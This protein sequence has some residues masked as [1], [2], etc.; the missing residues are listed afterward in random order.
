MRGDMIAYFRRYQRAIYIVVTVVIVVSF[1]FFGT[2]SSLTKG[3]FAG[4]TV[5][6]TLVDGTNVYRSDCT[7]YIQFLSTNPENSG[8][9]GGNPLNDGF[10][11]KAILN[12]P[13]GDQL[14]LALGQEVETDMTAKLEKEKKYQPYQHPQA[15]FVSAVNVWT[16]FAP[17]VKDHFFQFQKLP[18]NASLQEIYT[19]KKNLY[20]AERQFPAVYLKQILM[21]QQKQYSWLEADVTLESRNMNLMGYHSFEEWFGKKFLVASVLAIMNTAK[22]AEKEGLV[23]PY[24][25]AKLCLYGNAKNYV[26][27]YSHDQSISDFDKQKKIEEVINRTLVSYGMEEHDAIEIMRSL[28]LFQRAVTEIPSHIVTAKAPFQNFLQE[29]TAEA[30]L[31]V[32]RL[33]EWLRGKSLNDIVQV[34]FWIDSVSSA[35]ARGSNGLDLPKSFLPHQEVLK[36]VPELV[37]KRFLVSLA[38]VKKSNL[39]DRIRLKDLWTWLDNDENWEK[40]TKQFPVLLEK[41][42]SQPSD[43]VRIFDNLSGEIKRSVDNF[44][45]NDIVSTRQ[46]WLQEAL[47]NQKTNVEVLSIRALGGKKPLDGIQDQRALS[48]VLSEAPIGEAYLPLDQYTQDH[49]YYYKIVVLDR[50]PDYEIVPLQVALQDGTLSVL[51]HAFLK[52]QYA[53]IQSQKSGREFQKENGEYRDFVEIQDTLLHHVYATYT[54]KLDALIEKWSRELPEFTVWDQET[55]HNGVSVYAKVRYLPYLYEI[56]EV[57]KNQSGD[58]DTTL[59]QSMDVPDALDMSTPL[60]FDASQQLLDHAWRVEKVQ[61][62]IFRKDVSYGAQASLDHL[63]EEAP[64]S[65]T[66]PYY[67]SQGQVASFATLNEKKPGDIQGVLFETFE[68]A[69]GFLGD[70]AIRERSEALLHTMT[71]KDALR[72]VSL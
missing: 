68:A 72:T 36:T 2:Y 23:V 33:P 49:E 47:K 34:Q 19:A 13:F 38:K 39:F 16:Y 59:V 25:E 48:Q 71:E 11:E 32:Y 44:I 8:D 35:S 7:R 64:G 37:Q 56:A 58:I 52:A 29:S 70:E 60:H 46:D 3:S 15:P 66:K 10:L 1:S 62:T 22:I 55:D 28:L 53:K 67:D 9:G 21:Y 12:S 65:I 20:L 31:T 42:I 45:R 26:E 40:L 14:L 69:S 43:R 17:D 57:A 5:I 30:N 6:A 24:D 50:S 63:F 18:Q 27:R 61:K 51:V 4:D 54:K 41:K